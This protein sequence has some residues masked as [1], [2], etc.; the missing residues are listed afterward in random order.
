M[1]VHH[2]PHGA[3]ARGVW[4]ADRAF[5]GI[6]RRTDMG[7]ATPVWSGVYAR[8]GAGVDCALRRDPGGND[9]R[10]KNSLTNGSVAS[11]KAIFNGVRR[12]NARTTV[13]F[14]ITL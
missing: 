12:D 6:R 1:P 2:H 14:S 8:D 4:R 11:T 10:R 5:C 13:P 3:Q 9:A 7:P